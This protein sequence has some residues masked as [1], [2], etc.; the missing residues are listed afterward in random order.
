MIP[1][2]LQVLSIYAIAFGIGSSLVVAVDILSGRRQ[3]MAI[4]NFVW[5]LTSLWS[6]PAGLWLYALIGRPQ[7]VSH[8]NASMG[9]GDNGVNAQPGWISYVLATTHCGSG[10]ALGDLVAEGI[11]A[12]FSFSLFGHPVF[13]AW[14]L[15]YVLAFSF[16]ILFQYFTIKPMKGLSPMDGLKAALKADALSLTAWQIGM[17]GWMAL[18]FFLFLGREIP[19]TEPVFWFLMQI[20]MGAGFLTSLP[21]NAWLVRSG[22]KERMNA[23]GY[24]PSPGPGGRTKLI[25]PF[26]P[27]PAGV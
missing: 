2:W 11:Q 3:R 5:P 8:D 22:I 10:C 24:P 23:P 6:G 15:D 7:R 14:I 25:N 20:G 13:A 27:R 1:H 4:M 21:V 26:S 12:R 9:H 17:Y 19:P 18:C 16:G